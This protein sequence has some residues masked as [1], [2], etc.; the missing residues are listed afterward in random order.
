MEK[1]TKYIPTAI[2]NRYYINKKLIYWYQENIFT[3]K[4]MYLII[5]NTL[6]VF[7]YT[8]LGSEIV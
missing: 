7:K 1:S 4:T 3:T 2:I 6:D 8:I 5:N